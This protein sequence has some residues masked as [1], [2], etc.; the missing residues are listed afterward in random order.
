MTPADTRAALA[1]Y[2]AVQDPTNTP[3]NAALVRRVNAEAQAATALPDWW[4]E[5][6][7]LAVVVTAA[8]S[9]VWPW[10]WAA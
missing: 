3:A 2:M 5:A 9:A 4:P 10:G 1:H 7:A 8:L 6:A